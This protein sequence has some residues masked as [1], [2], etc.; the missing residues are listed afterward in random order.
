MHKDDSEQK[1]QSPCK[2][3]RTSFHVIPI[4]VAQQCI[5]GKTSAIATT[6]IEKNIFLHSLLKL[7]CLH[8]K[9]D[10]LYGLKHGGNSQV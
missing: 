4:L 5:T 3:E 1:H 8:Q 6:C 9:V 10:Q 7:N 2:E